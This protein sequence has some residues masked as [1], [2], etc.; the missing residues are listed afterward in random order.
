[1]YS[2]D[3][4]KINNNFKYIFTFTIS[5]TPKDILAIEDL[6]LIRKDGS[7]IILPTV[8]A[9]SKEEVFKLINR[10]EELAIESGVI[11]NGAIED[12][13]KVEEFNRLLK[14]QND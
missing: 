10:V 1:M 9:E 4:K 8:F 7:K 6:K 14:V 3:V 11:E 12:S 5:E 2:T 13:V